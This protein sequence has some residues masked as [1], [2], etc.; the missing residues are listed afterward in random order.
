[1][2]R[3][4]C[5]SIVTP[6]PTACPCTAAS[7]GLSKVAS[8]RITSIT[9]WAGVNSGPLRKSCRSLPAQNPAP[10]PRSSTARTAVAVCASPS[11]RAS[12]WYMA[13]VMALRFSGRSKRTSHTPASVDTRSC[14]LMLCAACGRPGPGRN[15]LPARV[16]GAP[17][18][19]RQGARQCAAGAPRERKS[20]SL[21]AASHTSAAQAATFCSS[22]SRST[23]SSVSSG[24][25]WM[26]K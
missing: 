5:S 22:C 2:T 18:G 24:V 26:S 13:K 11:E 6:M 12:A 9:G 23:L 16:D 10:S 17:C 4:Q 20:T 1:M 3:S 7:S 19:S 14:P 15:R 8:V 21:S 25:W